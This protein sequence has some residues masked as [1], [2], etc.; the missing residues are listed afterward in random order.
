[1]WRVKV[2]VTLINEDA[3]SEPTEIRCRIEE[4]IPGDWTGVDEWEQQVR[5]IGFSAMRRLFCC[6]IQL[7]EQQLL[8]TW[9]HRD[10]TCRLVKRGKTGITLAT[11]FGKVRV[12]RQRVLCRTCQQW[13]IPVNGSLGLGEEPCEAMTCGF[14][15]LLSFCALHQPYRQA[16]RMVGRITQDD[17]STSFKQIHR[18]ATRE[19]ARVRK[20]EDDDKEQTFHEAARPWMEGRP[21]P[22][23]EELIDG[24]LY[25]CLDGIYVRACPGRKRWREAKVGFL[26]TDAREVV[27]RRKKR[28]PTK[29]YVS[30]FVSGAT[31]MRK[32]YAEA[33]ELGF[34][35][36]R[37]VF[38][39]GDG[40]GWVRTIHRDAFS[41]AV[42]VLDWYHLREKVRRA[43]RQS[44]PD[45]DKERRRQRKEVL[46]DFWMGR[47]KMALHRLEALR[48][49]L[50]AQGRP[51][52]LTPRGGLNELIGYVEN[53]WDGIIDYGTM[54]EPGYMVASSL[55]EK[56]ADLVIAKRQK[57][58]QGMHWGWYGADGVAALRTLWLNDDWE[59][60]WEG[61]RRKAA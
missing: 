3:T 38:V 1:M 18:I 27:G 29:R 55:V 4:R 10:Q 41:T 52:I 44:L 23:P 15:E 21:P 13:L 35:R 31:L 17:G 45:D 14:K 25:I 60:Y 51:D 12:A 2:D 22:S 7:M 26:C 19:G 11:L 33:L 32:V 36:Y 37:E 54:Q 8:A 47:K 9:T 39:V 58:L 61:Q 50:V 30:G 28:V 56:A 48:A 46:A 42:Y 16:Q 40:A 20:R 59:A 43:F 57:K 6:G 34:G 5:H 49:R 53:N 24:V